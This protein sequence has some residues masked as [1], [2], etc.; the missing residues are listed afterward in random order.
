MVSDF[1]KVYTYSYIPSM[2]KINNNLLKGFGLM[3]VSGGMLLLQANSWFSIMFYILGLYAAMYSASYISQTD[4]V[5]GFLTR[6]G[7]FLMRIFWV[8]QASIYLC[9][10]KEILTILF[11]GSLGSGSFAWGVFSLL[12]FIRLHGLVNV[13][14]VVVGLVLVYPLMLMNKDLEK[15]C[16]TITHTDLLNN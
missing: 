6:M 11:M 1:P 2:L 9:L 10:L 7:I 5:V 3:F 16:T 15:Q 14:H 8:V 13:I 12:V 4:A